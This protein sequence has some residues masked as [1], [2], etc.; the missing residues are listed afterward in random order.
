MTTL[1][2]MEGLVGKMAR[3]ERMIDNEM[4]EVFKDLFEKACDREG[5]YSNGME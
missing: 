4:K 1:Q 5:A 3:D 2:E